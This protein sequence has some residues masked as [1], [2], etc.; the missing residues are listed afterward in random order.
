VSA[1]PSPP[2]A[3]EDFFTGF[4]L[5]SPGLVTATEW[6]TAEPAPVGQGPI[7]AG[8]GRMP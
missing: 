6:G 8:V 7:L 5:V 3:I 4:E 2:T 1:S